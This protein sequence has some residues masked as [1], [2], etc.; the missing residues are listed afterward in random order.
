MRL[1]TE[2]FTF[3]LVWLH[4]L[5]LSFNTQWSVNR[6]RSLL[7]K[8]WLDQNSNLRLGDSLTPARLKNY[9]SRRVARPTPLR[10]LLVLGV[11]G[12]PRAGVST[13]RAR[14]RRSERCAG[15]GK[16]ALP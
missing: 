16:H 7:A 9:N 5:F 10:M 13:K 2:A 15:V 6:P 1:A 8:T 3:I 12:T 4:R 14:E 11:Y